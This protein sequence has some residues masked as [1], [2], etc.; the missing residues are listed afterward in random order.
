[1]S[2]FPKFQI[3]LDYPYGMFTVRAESY[4]EFVENLTAT[5]GDETAEAILA[6][7]KDGFADLLSTPARQR[8]HEDDAQGK[9]ADG[10][11]QTS[12][13]GGGATYYLCEGHK[14]PMALRD[15]KRGKFWS[16]TAKI[17][18]GPNKGDFAFKHGEAC[19]PVDYVDGDEKYIPQNR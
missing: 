3:N 18:H 19:K 8:R 2:A 16:C 6:K 15:G 17:Q 5:A 4:D 11:I 13:A 9:L 12:R 7:I 14:E 1:M 10:G